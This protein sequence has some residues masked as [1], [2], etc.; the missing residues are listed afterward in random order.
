MDL[1]CSTLENKLSRAE[2]ESINPQYFMIQSEISQLRDTA[3]T[4][5]EER[6]YISKELGQLEHLISKNGAELAKNREEKGKLN[7]ELLEINMVSQRLIYF[8]L[9]HFLCSPLFMKVR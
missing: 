5:A 6:K 4:L 2:N 3:K 9:S 8:K 1:E 7:T